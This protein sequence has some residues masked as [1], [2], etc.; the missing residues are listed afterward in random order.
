M[1]IIA[2]IAHHKVQTSPGPSDLL[3]LADLHVTITTPRRTIKAVRGVD[4]NLQA[5]EI[6]ALVGESGSGKTMTAASIVGLLPRPAARITQGRILFQGRDLLAAGTRDR[7]RIL[8][9]DIAFI[10]QSSLT[11]LNPTSTIGRQLADMIAFRNGLDRREARREAVRWL[12][13]VGIDAA[14]RVMASYP[15]R[16]SGGMR[17][18]VLIAMAIN[19]RPKLIIA[20]EP[21][22]ALDTA[23]QKQ[24]LTLLARIRDTYGTAILLITHD[25]GVVSFLSDRIAVM[26]HGRIVET[27]PTARVLVAPRHPYTAT[28]I[29]AVPRLDH[30]PPR[31]APGV[32]SEQDRPAILARSAGR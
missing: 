26:Q 4:L 7:Q 20:D 29:D 3:R 15:H 27:G 8:R 24:I 12:G 9:Q 18:R 16:L 28:L 17:Q 5:G 32:I 19:S 11:S 23:T 10:V 21:T 1:S 22:T 30:P 6:L 2:P 25:F 31:P 14:E 13:E